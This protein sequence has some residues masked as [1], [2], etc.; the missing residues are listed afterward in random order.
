MEEL[1]QDRWFWVWL[2]IFGLLLGTSPFIIWQKYVACGIICGIVGLGGLL[3]LVRDRLATVTKTWPKVSL[4]ILAVVVLSMLVGQLMGYDITGHRAGGALSSLQ[5][6]FYGLTL[7]L[8]AVVVSATLSK[9]KT[10]KLVIHWANYRA[11]EGGGV[12][13]PVGDFLQQIISGDSLVFDI[14]NHNFVIGNKNFVPH[15][16]LTSKKKRLQVNYSYGGEPARTTERRE[17]GR[18]LLPEDSEVK[19]LTGEVAR[20]QAAQL[21]TIVGAGHAGNVPRQNDPRLRIEVTSVRVES[22]SYEQTCFTLHNE[23]LN[24]AYRVKI[25]DIDVTSPKHGHAIATFG[26]EEAIPAGKHSVISLV[27]DSVTTL[28]THDLKTF[29]DWKLESL[30]A[31]SKEVIEKITITYDDFSEN[32]FETTAELVYVP[33]QAHSYIEAS[34]DFVAIAK[35]FLG[36]NP[37]AVIVQRNE[38]PLISPITVRNQRF[39]KLGSK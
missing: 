15:D 27:I 36:K 23:G 6:W 5:W 14:E 4:K 1:P 16:P 34:E 28:F 19:W 26:Q 9:K 18:L 21:T 31:P 10:S 7:L 38:R 30:S 11:V 12:E 35:Q 39:K 37:S 17:H 29:L 20:L 22:A 3:M 33:I 13:Y 32:N 8:I 24:T 25:A 2:T